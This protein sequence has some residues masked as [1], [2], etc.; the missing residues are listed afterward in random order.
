MPDDRYIPCVLL[1]YQTPSQ[2]ESIL[3]VM[4][5][6]IGS[7]RVRNSVS[8]NFLGIS[9]SPTLG[10]ERHRESHFHFRERER[11]GGAAQLKKL[12]DVTFPSFIHLELSLFLPL[13]SF[14]EIKCLQLEF[15][16]MSRHFLCQGGRLIES[17]EISTQCLPLIRC[18]GLSQKKFLVILIH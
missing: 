7:T 17:G 6:L 18:K 10:P 14:P 13:P 5:T 1:E 2:K 8:P 4:Q 3:Q 16:K 12:F 11:E 15:G 9:P